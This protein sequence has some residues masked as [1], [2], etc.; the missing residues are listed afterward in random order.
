MSREAPVRICESLEVK[1]LWATR[2]VVC[3]EREEEAH[4]FVKQVEE[5]F[6]KFGLKVS[7]TKTRVIE[8]GRKAWEKAQKGVEKAGTFEFLGFTHYCGTTRNGKFKVGRKTAK[9]KYKEKVKAMKEWVKRVSKRAKMREWWKVLQ[10][11][12]MGHYRYY[13]V[14]GNMRSV[15]QWYLAVYWLVYKWINRRSQKRSYTLERY[16]RF[17][18]YNPLPRPKI[19]HDKYIPLTT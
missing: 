16:N 10:Q 18:K 12:M 17:L 6:A 1:F 7:V 2:L 14:S 15:R 8:F 4:R 9:G 19:Y 3:Y 11:K 13:G 5:R